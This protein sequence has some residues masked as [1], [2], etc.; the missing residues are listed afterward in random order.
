MQVISIIFLEKEL[1]KIRPWLLAQGFGLDDGFDDGLADGKE[2]GKVA[3]AA[4]RFPLE[5]SV[6]LKKAEA[7]L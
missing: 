1:S 2:L 6:S 3:A 7:V 5:V 4:K